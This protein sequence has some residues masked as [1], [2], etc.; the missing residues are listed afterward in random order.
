MQL[1]LKK[2]KQ[3][4][5]EPYLLDVYEIWTYRQNQSGCRRVRDLGIYF[6]CILADIGH[7][8]CLGR[9]KKQFD[10]TKL[11]KLLQFFQGK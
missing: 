2:N 3:G 7:K 9:V 10:I 5:R 11:L 8:D 4:M 6:P 1:L